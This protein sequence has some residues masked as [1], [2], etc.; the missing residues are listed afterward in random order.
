MRYSDRPIGLRAP[1]DHDG[2]VVVRVFVEDVVLT[3][4]R[5]NAAELKAAKQ[6]GTTREA[7]ASCMHKECGPLG[8][9]P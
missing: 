3:A 7:S 5:A 4:A 9:G 2:F 6:P 1:A 8:S